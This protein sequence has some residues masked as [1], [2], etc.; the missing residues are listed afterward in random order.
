MDL[1]SK[2][3]TIYVTNI[4]SYVSLS[5][6]HCQA[7]LTSYHTWVYPLRGLRNVLKYSA[8][9]KLLLL[10]YRKHRLG[11]IK[12]NENNHHGEMS[13]QEINILGR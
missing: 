5:P 2:Y 10:E 4:P 7:A 8:A 11:F 9:R 3:M 13:F 1:A 6:C 12:W